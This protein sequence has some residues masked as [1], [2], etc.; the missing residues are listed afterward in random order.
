MQALV[1]AVC[2]LDGWT[3]CMKSIG[4]IPEDDEY[5]ICFINMPN[6]KD[7]RI[8]FISKML[9]TDYAAQPVVLVD[10]KNIQKDEWDAMTELQV[11]RTDTN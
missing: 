4:E 6:G 7:V 10:K 5:A 11:R 1:I 3:D 2:Y 8:I 9:K